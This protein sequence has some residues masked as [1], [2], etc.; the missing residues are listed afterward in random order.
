MAFENWSPTASENTTVG[1][2]DI[3]EG[4]PPSNLNNAER[5]IM[6]ELRAAFSTALAGFFAAGDINSARAILNAFSASGGAIG[7]NI[8]RSGAGPHLY[9]VGSDFGSGRIFASATGAPNPMS[10]AGDIWITF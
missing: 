9:W 8:V 5:E 2:I 3:S 10:Q 7:G 4:C 6:A 1:G